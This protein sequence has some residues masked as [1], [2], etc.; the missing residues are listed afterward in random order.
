MKKEEVKFINKRF[1]MIALIILL[2][3]VI[4]IPV[5]TIIRKVSLDNY[6]NAVATFIGDTSTIAKPADISPSIYTFNCCLCIFSVMALACYGGLRLITTDWS[7]FN[8]KK[9]VSK[10]W[11]CILLAIF[12][13]WT[14]VGCIQAG[15]EAGAEAYVRNH[16]EADADYNYYLD[17]ASWSETERMTNAADR[18]WNG[19][20]N[21]KDGYF[22]FMFYAAVLLNILMLGVDSEDYKRYVMRTLLISS[23][24][25]GILTL[26]SLYRFSSLYGVLYYERA[27]FN[28]RNHFGYYISVICMLAVTMF[29][30]EKNLYFKGI[31]F[32][33]SLIYIF[34]TFVCDTFGAY[35]G[36]LAAMIFLFIITLYK[37]IRKKEVKEFVCALVCILLFTFLTFSF[38]KTVSKTY[39]VA[40]EMFDYSNLFININGNTYQISSNSFSEE[41]ADELK[42]KTKEIDGMNL[43]FGTQI[44]KLDKAKDAFVI[45]NFKALFNDLGKF[46]GYYDKKA[47]EAS[48]EEAVK[49]Y[50]KADLENKLAEI[51]AKYPQV[52]G[53]SLEEWQARQTTIED[54]FNKFVKD[55]NI[56]LEA[57]YNEAE[58]EESL[59]VD[60]LEKVGSG[61]APVW[62]RSLDLMNQRPWFGWGLENLLNEFYTQYNISEGRTHNLILQLGGTTG[63]P[64]VIMYLVATIAIFIKLLF[65]AKFRKF[66]KKQ[67]A[68]IFAIFL[69]I[70]ILLN[71]LISSKTDKLLFNGLITAAV[72]AFLVLVT[73][74]KKLHLRIGEWNEFEFIGGT[75]FVSYMVSS[76]FGN[77]AFYTSPYF[78]IFLGMIT[79]EVLHK[80]DYFGE[81]ELAE[82]EG[83][84]PIEKKE[85]AKLETKTENKVEEKVANNKPKQNTGNKKK[86]KKRK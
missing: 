39:Q 45:S 68:I 20:D 9:F 35:L 18:S 25:I 46:L 83:T 40:G 38:V 74:T 85:V 70:T 53:E 65:D 44:T 50:T 30:K 4:E 66:N 19:C 29:I 62:I 55:N 57:I 73:F 21:L 47:S 58:Q 80:K 77:S 43:Y 12:M 67:L 63:I 52:S 24:V 15:M 7:K 6:T 34:L 3:L 69:V 56:D 60:E 32:M 16:T 22:S 51:S 49:T 36:V 71:V 28:N 23:L 1:K 41:K 37:L 11:V 86:S 2:L 17:I 10:N 8:F 61:R 13:I 64:G 54:E 72:F 42:I 75:I 76:I 5:F 59:S 48:G 14:S 84:K 31:A 27:T 26:L 82:V 33:N 78:M 81:L 79:F